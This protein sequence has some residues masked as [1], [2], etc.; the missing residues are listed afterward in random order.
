MQVI[1]IWLGK[2]SI[3]VAIGAGWV[4]IAVPLSTAIRL[5]PVRVSIAQVVQYV[6]GN[7]L[8]AT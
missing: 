4:T 6:S 5:Q 7:L 8:R 3:E 1:N 2:C